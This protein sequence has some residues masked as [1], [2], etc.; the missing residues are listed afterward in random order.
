MPIAVLAFLMKL[1]NRYLMANTL[2]GV[3]NRKMDICDEHFVVYA[4]ECNPD[5]MEADEWWEKKCASFGGDDGIYFIDTTEIEE[6]AI[7]G[8]SEGKPSNLCIDFSI[9]E[10]VISVIWTIQRNRSL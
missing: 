3:H 5:D 1:H 4:D 8:T 9:E 7:A 6:L 10:P 2:D